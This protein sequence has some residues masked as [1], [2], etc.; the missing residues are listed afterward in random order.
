VL[1]VK[2]VQATGEA[3]SPQKRTFYE[4]CGPPNGEFNPGSGPKPGLWIPI[5]IHLS[6]WIRIR[7]ENA[8][9]HPGGQ[10]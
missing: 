5:R 9:P 3:L 1:H 10:K 8:D 4:F 7:I 6:R 2:E